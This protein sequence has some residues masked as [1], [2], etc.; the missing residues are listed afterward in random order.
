MATHKNIQQ[1]GETMDKKIILS[2]LIVAL[3]GI[4]AATYQINTGENVLNPLSSVE[5]E[6]SPVTE[7][8]TA[9]E[10]QQ[11]TQAK[12]QE[13]AQADAQAK[14]QE[15]AKADAQKQSQAEQQT[16]DDTQN[17]PTTGSTEKRSS[18]ISADN[19]ITVTN[20]DNQAQSTGNTGSDNQ[21]Q[22]SDSQSQSSDSQSQ[23]T[24]NTGSDSQ[25]QSTDNTGDNSQNQDTTTSTDTT[26]IT[27]DVKST[28]QS[29]LQPKINSDQLRLDMD[30][31]Q[32]INNE[33]QI[34]AYDKDNQ[35]AGTFYVDIN[36]KKWHFIDKNGNYF[37]EETPEPGNPNNGQ[38]DTQ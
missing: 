1:Q 20:T 32:L 22:S 4:V 37:T 33:Y 36:S 23:N 16:Q 3:I 9:P 7:V 38:L 25:S 10:T 13:Q 30:N 8:L 2:V 26:Q 28:I 17:Q 18:Q 24:G 6:K 12:A 29:I 5:T 11:D 27:D 15:Q 34:R 19:P 21:A 31:C 35:F 14:A